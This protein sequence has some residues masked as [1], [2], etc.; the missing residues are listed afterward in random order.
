MATT[1]YLELDSTYRDRVKWPSP[2]QFE[3]QIAQS[4]VK[5]KDNAVDPVCLSAPINVWKGNAFATAGSSTVVVDK[6]GTTATVGAGSAGLK[7]YVKP[8]TGALQPT[9]N[10][11]VGAIISWTTATLGTD[12][13]R[14]IGYK[15]ISVDGAGVVTDAMFEM[16][17][18]LYIGWSTGTAFTIS[19][20]TDF[21]ATTSPYIFVP[22]GRGGDNAYYGSYI[23]NQTVGEYRAITSYDGTTHIAQIESS[24]TAAVGSGIVTGWSATDVFCI[25]KEIPLFVGT[26]TIAAATPTTVV[27]SALA[28][29]TDNA[30]KNFFLRQYSTTDPS[31][32][33]M[34]RITAYDGATQTATVHP[35]F[36]GA[37]VAGPIEVLQFSYDN[38]TPFTYTSGFIGQQ[39]EVCYELELTDLVLPNIALQSGYGSLTAFYP[40]LYVELRNTTGSSAG[41]KNTLCS[42]NPNSSKM[43]FR[44]AI[45]DIANPRDQAF[46]TLRSSSVHTI[47][48]KANDS[49]RFGVYLPDGSVFS[50]IRSEYYSPLPAN[51]IVQVSAN[52]SL[53]RVQG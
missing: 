14:I 8:K 25:R 36:G 42:N 13:K 6:A 5:N 52:F 27:L 19:D 45:D 16:D 20:P 1:K 9:E 21:V 22:V 44:V 35:A 31:V 28:S 24:G 3:V 34:R 17:T 30:Y 26:A 51:S 33:V 47:K 46:I 23:Y 12:F 32:N 2:A 29:T 39:E 15:A 7:I 4:G 49:M 41:N 11:Y 18:D 43:L 48:F 50:T 10:Y 37:Y 38:A 53:K 40:Y